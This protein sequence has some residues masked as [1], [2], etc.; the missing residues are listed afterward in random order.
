MV[1][2]CTRKSRPSMKN[3]TQKHT[4]F[5]KQREEIDAKNTKCMKYVRKNKVQYSLF[6]IVL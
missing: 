2:R 5:I 4:F 1:D 3:T 6:K